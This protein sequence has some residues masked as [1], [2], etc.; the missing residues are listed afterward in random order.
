MATAGQVAV[1]MEHEEHE[2]PEAPKGEVELNADEEFP[3]GG[4][5]EMEFTWLIDTTDKKVSKIGGYC[6]YYYIVEGVEADHL[7]FKHVEPF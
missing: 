2:N 4:F 6:V 3:Y 1:P 7:S 5:D